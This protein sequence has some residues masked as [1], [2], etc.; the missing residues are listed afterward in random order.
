MQ[1]HIFIDASFAT[2]DK[3]RSHSGSVVRIDHA[4]LGC[5]SVKQKLNTKSSCE[6]E[7]VAVSDCI[8]EVIKFK[9]ILT[10]IGFDVP[11]PILHQDNMSTIALLREGRPKSINTRHIAI[12]FFFVH[13]LLSQGQIKMEYTNTNEMLGDIFTKPI[14]G[15]RFALLRSKVLGITSE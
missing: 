3:M 7:L 9:H 10:E 8:G 4:T 11:A 12:K 2:H 5:K 1:L 6:S 13:D 15:A 14:Q